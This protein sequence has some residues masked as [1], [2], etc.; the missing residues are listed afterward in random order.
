MMGYPGFGGF[1][2][3]PYGMPPMMPPLQSDSATSTRRTNS[4]EPSS[5]PPDAA[6]A[7]IYPLIE[8]FME[9]LALR[10]PQRNL[11]GIGMFFTFNDYFHIDEVLGLTQG[12]VMKLGFGITVGK[13]RF[14]L[15]QVDDEMHEAGCKRRKVRV[16]A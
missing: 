8:T 9:S 12:E 3:P 15:N 14:I 11:D 10:H 5:D 4:A 16:R 6:A 7:R 1:W 13:A 2:A